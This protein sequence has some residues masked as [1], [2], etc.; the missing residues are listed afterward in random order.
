MY[1][2]VTQFETVELFAR[3]ERSLREAWGRPAQAT[4]WWRRLVGGT[5]RTERHEPRVAVTR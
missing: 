1:P 2:D 5:T 3:E 4:P